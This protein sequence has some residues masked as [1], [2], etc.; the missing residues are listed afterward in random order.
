MHNSAQSNRRIESAMLQEKYRKRKKKK[1]ETA[2]I[3][4]FP[5]SVCGMLTV[6]RRDLPTKSRANSCYVFSFLSFMYNL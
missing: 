6:D 5:L 4:K 2:E 3:T 1:K